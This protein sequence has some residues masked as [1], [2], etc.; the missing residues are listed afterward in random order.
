MPKLPSRSVHTDS[1]A[2]PLIEES[3]VA[4]LYVLLTHPPDR[5]VADTDDL[6]RLQPG[7]VLLYRVRI[8]F[9]SLITG[10]SFAA[11][12]ARLVLNTVVIQSEIDG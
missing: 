10:S 2:P 11:E 9:C 6:G 7:D 5:P 4:E 8:T 1:S 12:I 3:V